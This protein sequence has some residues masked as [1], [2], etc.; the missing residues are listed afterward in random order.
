[1]LLATF[2]AC[3]SPTTYQQLNE[4][5]ER[6]GDYSKVEA[7]EETVDKATMYYAYKDLCLADYNHLWYCTAPVSRRR[8]PKNETIDQFVRRYKREHLSCNCL[9]ISEFHR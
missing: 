1:M 9:P 6:T 7:F 5:A 4:E 3:A 8:I 2:A